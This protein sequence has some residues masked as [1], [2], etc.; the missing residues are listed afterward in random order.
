VEMVTHSAI[1]NHGGGLRKERERVYANPCFHAQSAFAAFAGATPVAI[2]LE[3]PVERAPRVLP[4]LRHAVTE[5]SFGTIDA[6]AAL[7]PEGDLLL[8]LVHRGSAGPIQL[9]VALEGF[10]PAASGRLQILTA[11]QPWA[12]NTLE[13]PEAVKL[14]QSDVALRDQSIELKLPPYT[15]VIARI[16]PA[17]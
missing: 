10:H 1:I 14:V 11:N 4:D 3:A 15:V 7:A 6:L 9:H 17:K 16:P 13:H 12:A 5:V 2:E 8:S